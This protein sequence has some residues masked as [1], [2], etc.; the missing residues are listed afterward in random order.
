M[1][2]VFKLL[3]FESFVSIHGSKRLGRECLLSRVALSCCLASLWHC[4]LGALPWLDGTDWWTLVMCGL[5]SAMS[6]CSWASD[7][8]AGLV[9]LPLIFVMEMLRLDPS[10]IFQRRYMQAPVWLP[11]RED[12]LRRTNGWLYLCT[13][14]HSSGTFSN[15][16]PTL[17]SYS[18]TY[19]VLTYVYLLSATAYEWNNVKAGSHMSKPWGVWQSPLFLLF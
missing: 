15:Y 6:F 9:R 13:V 10:Q 18:V 1:Q 2:G 16:K 19:L 12:I 4:F 7:S 8:L 3:A 11:R 14:V 17:G 5:V